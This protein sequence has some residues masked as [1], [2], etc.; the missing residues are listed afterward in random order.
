MLN[1]VGKRIYSPAI[2]L[3]VTI[4]TLLHTDSMTSILIAVL[5]GMLMM[6]TA[7]ILRVRGIVRLL[8]LLVLLVTLAAF[9][10]FLIIEWPEL[11]TIHGLFSLIGRNDSLTGR[12]G[13]WDIAFKLIAQ[14]PLL[15]WGY[16]ANR[17]ALDVVS[18]AYG[19]FHNGY[20]D[21]LVR[22]G[23]IGLI[24]VIILLF[25]MLLNAYQFAHK[26][27]L[28]SMAY[29]IL[30]LEIV[31]HNM[32]EASIMRPA[33]P[34]WLTFITMYFYLRAYKKVFNIRAINSDKNGKFIES[35]TV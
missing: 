28:Y 31:T 30:I 9:V 24:I 21:L 17:S 5:S 4:Y 35:V 27:K 19:Q 25:E 29:L 32:T 34:L 10:V 15:G 1:D 14:R 8:R 11:M 12:T 16:D 33:H 22:G 7:F 26:N 23:M 13:L 18:L 3:T 6:G 20:L 2:L